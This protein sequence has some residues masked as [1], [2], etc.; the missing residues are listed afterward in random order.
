MRGKPGNWRK[1]CLN[2]MGKTFETKFWYVRTFMDYKDAEAEPEQIEQLLKDMMDEEPDNPAYWQLLGS[3]MRNL[4]EPARAL[5]A[6]LRARRSLNERWDYL[7][8]QIVQVAEE[9][10]R[11]QENDPDY[12]DWWDMANVCWLGHRYDRVRLL[13]EDKEPEEKQRQSWLF[14]MAGSCHELGDYKAAVQYRQK[15]WDI[16][17]PEER[18]LDLFLD[19]AGDY[20]QSGDIERALTLYGEAQECFPGDPEAFYQKGRLLF[21]EER[22][23]EAIEQCDQVLKN[24]FHLDT[25]Y[26]RL[27]L[28]LELERYEEVRDDV[29]Q[30]VSQG[31]R[32]AQ[33]LF[34]YA[35][36]LRRLEENEE[37]ESVLKELAERTGG[38][39]AVCQEY[40]R[41]CSDTDRPQEALEWIEKA[42]KDRDTPMRQLM[43][44]G[45]LYDLKRYEEAVTSYE[46]LIGQGMDDRYIYNRMGRASESMRKFKEAEIYYRKA[47]EIDPGYGVAWDNLGDVLQ[48]QGKWDEAIEAYEKGWGCGN[49]QAIRDLCRILKRTHVDEKAMEYLQQGLECFPDDGNL[50]W[51]KAMMLERLKKYEEAIRCMGRYMEVKPSQTS[52]AYREIASCWEDMKDYP[53]AEEYYQKAIDHDPKEA[54][55]WRM[56]GKYYAN[57]RKMQEEALPYLEKAVELAP[58][59]L[60]GWMKLGEVYEAL[61][62]QDEAMSCYETCLKNYRLEIEKDPHDCCNYEGAADVLIHLGRLDE[63]EEMAH[64]AISLQ[65]EVFYCSCPFCYEALEDLAKLEEKRGNLEKA[66]EWMKLAGRLGTTD[67]YPKEIARLEKALEEQ[68][69][70]KGEAD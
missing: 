39:G 32:N 46:A 7:E 66:L 64:H 22:Y 12:D 14:M 28:L 47:V 30:V 11:L 52:S 43:R 29:R 19:L 56:F 24:G 42:I 38:S 69:T 63:A 41:L 21:D 61:G 5:G 4:G 68:R 53:K 18:S 1:I 60:Y 25:F 3:H 59:S 40:A 45:Y 54:K 49:R 67:Y 44:G 34:Y 33:V 20:R 9:L 65:N 16:T 37:A 31:L 51:I 6:Y 35:R 70:E 13:L 23:E 27:E 55:N 8:E 62:R 17:D 48:D 36:A 10:S 58:D 50:L 26:L 15:I 2:E 57:K